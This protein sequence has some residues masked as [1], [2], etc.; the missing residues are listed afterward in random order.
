[1]AAVWVGQLETPRMAARTAAGYGVDVKPMVS[2]SVHAAPANLHDGDID[3]VQRRAAHDSGDSHDRF[4]SFC[5]SLSS[6][7]A[8]MGR[9][10]SRL[11]LR[12]RSA[13]P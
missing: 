4:N 8:S 1:M 2:T 5:N 11:R 10:S 3:A 7:S 6:C 9:S 13:M 12:M